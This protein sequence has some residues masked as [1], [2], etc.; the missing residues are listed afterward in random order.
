MSEYICDPPVRIHA[1]VFPFAKTY[2]DLFLKATG[3]AVIDLAG[4][5]TDKTKQQQQKQKQALSPLKQPAEPK[6]QSKGPRIEAES[7]SPD[8]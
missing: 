6:A 1:C 8:I 3:T 4:L 2:R 7:V 5:K